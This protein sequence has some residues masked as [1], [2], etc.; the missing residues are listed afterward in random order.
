MLIKE[1]IKQEK[2]VDKVY[3]ILYR[4]IM[5]QTLKPGER[6][7]ESEI[8]EAL[9]VSRT[10]LREA[11]AQLLRNGLLVELPRKGVCVVRLTQKEVEEIFDIR[12]ALEGYAA[13]LATPLLSDEDL[14]MLIKMHQ[15]AEASIDTNPELALA[16]DRNLHQ[17]LIDKC[18][19]SR[20]ARILAELYDLVQLFRAQQG[21]RTETVKSLMEHRG[22]IIDALRKRDEELAEKL[23][24][25]H[26]RSVKDK[27]MAD[28][29]YNE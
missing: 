14:A 23:M 3:E 1:E 22:I 25:E 21:R 16:A 8:T 15:E 10:P 5:N 17:S 12:I 24:R 7:V 26:I 9:N 19:N 11:I 2:L 6:I 29:L 18:Q 13:R 27:V 4:H 20:I 28:T